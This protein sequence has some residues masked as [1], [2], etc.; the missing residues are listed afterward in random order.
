MFLVQPPSFDDPL[1]HVQA[2]EAVLVQALV[3]EATVEALNQGVLQRLA[4]HEK[5]R[6]QVALLP[7]GESRS[8]GQLHDVVADDDQKH[9]PAGEHVVE[10]AS[11]ADA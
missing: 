1:G 7:P 6:F 11:E 10:F 5:V 9:A 2:P 4:S 8:A 3:A